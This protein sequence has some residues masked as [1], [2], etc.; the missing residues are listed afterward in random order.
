M[1]DSPISPRLLHGA[2]VG[3]D[4][5]N[6]V[7]SVI[8][9]QYNPDSMTRRLEGRFSGSEQADRG[10]A[11]RIQGPPRET[12]TL[13]VE[14]DEAD[15]PP[16]G[17]GPFSGV[18]A[19]LAA[20]EM[21]LYPKTASVIANMVAAAAGSIEVLAPRAPLTLF[22]WGPAR[23]LPVRVSGMTITEQQYDTLLNPTRAKVDLT[24][25]VLSYHDLKITNPGQAIFLAHQVTKELLAASNATSSVANL[26]VS[27]KL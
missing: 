18:Q 15:H 7:A 16:G 6:P 19:P 2:I 17:R 10:E 25:S 8:A 14:F 23:V 4:P 21:L 27:L 1:T 22:V 12:I 20:L 3:L 11:Q 9:F 13:A 5:F 24:L 26:G